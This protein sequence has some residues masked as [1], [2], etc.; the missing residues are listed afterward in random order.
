MNTVNKD[1]INNKDYEMILLNVSEW[2]NKYLN[3]KSIKC[4]DRFKNINHPLVSSG[5][6]FWFDENNLCIGYKNKK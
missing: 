4:K 1:Y 5:K 6:A 3:S 2:K